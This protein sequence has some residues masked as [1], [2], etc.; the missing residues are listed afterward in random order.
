MTISTDTSLISNNN[1]YACTEQDCTITIEFTYPPIPRLYIEMLMLTQAMIN[2]RQHPLPRER[3]IRNTKSVLKYVRRILREIENGEREYVDIWNPFIFGLFDI[4]LLD[5]PRHG[6]CATSHFLY[7]TLRFQVVSNNRLMWRTVK[8][9]S[10]S[11][12]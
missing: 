1:N 5:M 6:T 7:F 4:T 11:I 12:R 3:A 10:R 2:I 8:E 9:R